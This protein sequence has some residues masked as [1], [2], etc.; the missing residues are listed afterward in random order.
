MYLIWRK[1]PAIVASRM[2]DVTTG[3]VTIARVKPRT[4]EAGAGRE[5]GQLLVGEE[6]RREGRE[7]VHLAGD[8]RA[9]DGASPL[10]ARFDAGCRSRCLKTSVSSPPS[11]PSSSR[12]D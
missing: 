5:L 11:S 6:M 4:S 2:N 9:L 8:A 1:V 10:G 12:R 7:V 3:D